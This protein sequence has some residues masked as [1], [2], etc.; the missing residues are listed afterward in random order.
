VHRDDAR[1][2]VTSANFTSRA[3]SRSVEVGI[4]LEDAAFAAELAEH[5]RRL[6]SEALLTRYVPA[7]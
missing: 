2:L 1:A 3:Q 7:G 4:L 5:W 6:L